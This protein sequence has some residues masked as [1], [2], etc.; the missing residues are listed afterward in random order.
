MVN[1][2]WGMGNGEFYAPF[3]RDVKNPVLPVTAGWVII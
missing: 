3:K 1:D 2:E